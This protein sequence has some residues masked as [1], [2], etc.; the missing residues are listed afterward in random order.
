MEITTHSPDETSDLGATLGRQLPERAI[1]TLTGP[2]G[3][4]KT[5]FIQGLVA[6]QSADLVSSPTYVYHQRYHGRLGPID[7]VDL[8][9][10]HHDPTL[11]A[12]SGIDELLT[13][14]P[15]WLVIEW[16]LDDLLY[17]PDV[18]LVQIIARAGPRFHFYLVASDVTLLRALKEV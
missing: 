10:V 13:D 1:V 3:S 18:V 9:R 2:L 12:R 17:P 15:G 4:G 8:Y 14:L 16:P 6:S 7:H 11:R 5:T